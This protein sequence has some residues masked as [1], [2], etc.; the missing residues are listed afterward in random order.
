MHPAAVNC[1]ASTPVAARIWYDSCVCSLAHL[2]VVEG[3]VA[4]HTYASVLDQL[5]DNA[6]SRQPEPRQTLPTVAKVLGPALRH[7]AIERH[8][9]NS[10]ASH[11]ADIFSTVVG[12]CA[13]CAGRLQRLRQAAA[14]TV[15]EATVQQHAVG[16]TAAEHPAAAAAE[17]QAAAAA[18]EVDPG[19][20]S[21]LRAI[22]ADNAA[23]DHGEADWPTSR[24]LPKVSWQRVCHNDIIMLPPP[25]SSNPTDASCHSAAAAAHLYPPLRPTPTCRSMWRSWSNRSA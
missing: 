25:T 17:Q 14:P 23:P 21:L 8:F 3:G 22:E 19:L 15:L 1:H 16:P 7:A 5:A 18:Q 24:L 13:P 12:E 9:N 6:E 4:A 2:L 20:D 10:P 11:G